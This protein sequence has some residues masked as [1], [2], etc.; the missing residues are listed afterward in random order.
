[1]RT[2]SLAHRHAPREGDIGRRGRLAPALLDYSERDAI[3]EA[4]RLSA[5]DEFE[6]R[7]RRFGGRLRQRWTKG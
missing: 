1:M 5:G 6:G 7:E 4:A 3:L 2:R